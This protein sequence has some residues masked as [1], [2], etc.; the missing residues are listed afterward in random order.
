[1]LRHLSDEIPEHVD[2]S[3]VEKIDEDTHG[4]VTL[5]ALKRFGNRAVNSALHTAIRQLNT[6]V[7]RTLK[8]HPLT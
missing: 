6:K 1:M 8:Q 4:V 2:V 3:G 7:D 5:L